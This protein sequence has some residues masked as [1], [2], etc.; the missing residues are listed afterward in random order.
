[1]FF[2][3]PPAPPVDPTLSQVV[4]TMPR[5][6]PLPGEAAYAVQTV[7]AE[8]LGAAPR[9][10]AALTAVPGVS[11]FRRTSSQGANPTSQ[12]VSL[13]A[14]AGSGASRAL[15]TL[16]GVPLND[17]F[18]GWVV[19]SAVPSASIRSAQI[20]KGAGA[21]PYGSGALTGVIALQEGAIADGL[22]LISADATDNGDHSLFASAGTPVPGGRLGLS[23]SH[24]HSDGW[25]PVVA[26][27]GSAD[28]AL[29]LDASSAA[30][31]YVGQLGATKA[32]AR[33]AAYDERRDS[34]LKGAQSHARGAE[35]SLSLVGSA[36]AETSW[37]L[38][39]WLS[40]SNL[41]N[42]AVST[43]AGRAATTP[44]NRQYATP[45]LG[46]GLNGALRLVQGELVLEGGADLR[47]STGEVHEDFRYQS[48]R[49]TR[50]R[51]AGGD[52]LTTGLYG[53]ASL[54]KGPWLF[55]GGARVD[56]WSNSGAHRLERDRASGAT[57]LNLHPA[58]KSGVLP[59]LRAGVKRELGQGLFLRSAAYLGFR[60]PTLNEL[61]RPFRV[62]NDVTEANSALKPER[63][64]GAEFGLGQSFKGGQ[65]SATAFVSRLRDAISNVTKASGPI[66]DSVAGFI[67]AGGV[68]RQRQNVDAV[69]AT[70]LEVSARYALTPSLDVRFEAVATRARMEGGGAAPQLTGLHPAQTPE[71]AALVGLSWKATSRLMLRTD[72]RYEGRRFDDDQNLRP[73]REGYSGSFAAE[74]QLNPQL[75]AFVTAENLGQRGQTGRDASGVISY[76][77]PPT[78]RVGLR[79]RH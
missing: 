51:N 3:E 71:A 30:L 15:V 36:G 69:N 58:D 47:A 60:A 18:G 24:E 22:G 59:T 49:F 62:G 67:P 53:E 5:L 75:S 28:S 78:V 48:G 41:Y 17:P 25:T 40:G 27:R 76:A 77:A 21:G 64:A 20:I 44:A 19:W 8:A 33:L 54:D 26:G 12:G 14:I 65:W 50:N 63:L 10:D 23:L 73:L 45:A 1:M 2:A 29:T 61:H 7:D 56:Y 35:A 6:A 57:T 42:T 16:D 52:A 55:T 46:Y 38:Q 43:T 39:G 79:L 72:L 32:G 4:V 37:R 13:R 31:R 70:G 66:T 68:L 9:L 34:G 11:L 74:A